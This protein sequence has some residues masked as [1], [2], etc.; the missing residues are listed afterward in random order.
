MSK[1][2]SVSIVEDQWRPHCEPKDQKSYFSNKDEVI[3]SIAKE[4]IVIQIQKTQTK[5]L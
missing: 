3:A 2:I 5:V 1:F 4:V